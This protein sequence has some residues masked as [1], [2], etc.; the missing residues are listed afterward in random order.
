MVID[1]DGGEHTQGGGSERMCT[2]KTPQK[3]T[4]FFFNG[5]NF[6]DTCLTSV[7]PA[8]RRSKLFRF[9]PYIFH[10]S[11][12]SRKKTT[13]EKPLFW[14]LK[15]PIFCNSPTAL[16]TGTCTALVISHQVRV[17]FR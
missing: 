1:H 17:N 3:W 8:N 2:L 7:D 12:H 6:F 14:T 11:E 4:F 9:D 10:A 5:G 16:D 13:H 15:E